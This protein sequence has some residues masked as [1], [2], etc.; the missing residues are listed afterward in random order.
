MISFV[1][2]Y[3]GISILEPGPPHTFETIVR[4]ATHFE[5]KW[6]PPREPNGILIGYQIS[7]QTS[8][9]ACVTAF[10]SISLNVLRLYNAFANE[11]INS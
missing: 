10:L 3:T 7:Y 8:K 4:G 11:K 6:T 5:L 1:T 9:S 2:L